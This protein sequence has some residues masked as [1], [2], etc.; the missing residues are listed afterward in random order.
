[1]KT[2]AAIKQEGLKVLREKM[3]MVDMERFIVLLNREKFDYTIWRKEVFENM[4]IDELAQKGDE[5]SKGL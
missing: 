5:Y 1:M 2:D 3:G 4:S